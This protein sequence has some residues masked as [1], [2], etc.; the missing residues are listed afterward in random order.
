MNS[1]D[2]GNETPDDYL[3]KLRAQQGYMPVGDHFDELRKRLIFTILY[4]IIFSIAASFFYEMIWQFLM[5]PV[6]KFVGNTSGTPVKIIATKLTDFFAVKF[7]LIIFT[8]VLA[9]TPLIIW[10]I[11]G[12]M[13]PAFSGKT[14]KWGWGIIVA[15]T[16][17]FWGGVIFCRFGVWDLVAEM[18]IFG[19]TPPGISIENTTELVQAE[20]HITM[21]DYLSMFFAFHFAFGVSFEM[22]VVSVIL[23]LTGIL[24]AKMFWAN[25]RMAIL[26]IAVVS[27]ILTPADILSMLAMMVPLVILFLLSGLLVGMI[28]KNSKEDENAT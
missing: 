14:R 2:S 1:S 5:G 28:E 3:K 25:W 15:A 13:L 21:A 18:L 8:G 6:A 17:L 10:E 20:L 12:F 27:A 16:A 7:K 9:A 11:W 22:P 24:K 26:V 19:W 4:V 23:A